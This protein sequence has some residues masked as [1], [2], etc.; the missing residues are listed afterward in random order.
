M[1]DRE[2]ADRIVALGVGV[3]AGWDDRDS[4]AGRVILY[5]IDG[6]LGQHPGPFVRDRRVAVALMEKMIAGEL[7]I[8]RQAYDDDSPIWIVETHLT[9]A[10]GR[11]ESL[12]RAISEA[13]VGALT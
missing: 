9:N 3:V 10:D 12:P 4:V 13:C 6:E 1:N 8:W 7:T 11:D 2:L 5:R